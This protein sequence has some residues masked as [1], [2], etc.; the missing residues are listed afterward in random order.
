M[1]A[2]ERKIWVNDHTVNIVT[3]PSAGEN[4]L[5]EIFS[6]SGQLAFSQQLTLNEQTKV[7]VN[8]SGLFIIRVT[9]LK[10]VMVKKGFLK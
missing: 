6:M 8:L 4:A 2:T 5:V 9:T 1:P 3:S 7:P 10:D